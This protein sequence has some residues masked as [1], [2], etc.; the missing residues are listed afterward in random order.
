M[1][2]EEVRRGVDH[3]NE[4]RHRRIV[5]GI[6]I[7]SLCSLTVTVSNYLF[8]DTVDLGAKGATQSLEQL[9]AL[10]R[11]EIKLLQD[12]LRARACSVYLLAAATISL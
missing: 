7:G 9:R 12:L 11:R 6:V 5:F 8:L 2:V 10:E 4:E 1:A 3:A